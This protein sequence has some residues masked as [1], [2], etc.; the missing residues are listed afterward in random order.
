MAA[1]HLLVIWCPTQVS[2]KLAASTGHVSTAMG[3]QD[4]G[5]DPETGTA[6]MDPTT[7]QASQGAQR[8]GSDAPLSSAA[9]KQ[10]R[11]SR[12]V[13]YTASAPALPHT[14]HAL[15]EHSFQQR[16]PRFLRKLDG[17]VQVFHGDLDPDG[18]QLG[19]HGNP[20]V[21]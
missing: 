15:Q 14:E 19:G 3:H 18:K 20:D 17:C 4:I 16:K 12:I 8:S 1:H 13:Y 5:Y 9:D 21:S 7:G 11:R 2:F 6:S 10:V